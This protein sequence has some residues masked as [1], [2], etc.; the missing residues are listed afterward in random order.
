M[1]FTVTKQSSYTPN[2]VL[3]VVDEGITVGR[4]G[5]E[6][7]FAK[8]S[9]E[10]F[11]HA[12]VLPQKTTP[13]ASGEKLKSWAIDHPVANSTERELEASDDNATGEEEELT[14]FEEE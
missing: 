9:G 11:I 2:P 4:H 14:E 1:T 6:D 12:L 8:G 3:T 10:G 13:P 7:V 5:F